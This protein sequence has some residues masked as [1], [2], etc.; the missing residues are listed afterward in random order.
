MIVK[1][2]NE[3]CGSWAFLAILLSAIVFSSCDA[4]DQPTKKE[5]TR[6]KLEST[7]PAKR[8]DGLKEAEQ[9]YGK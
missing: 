1:R 3:R 9:K 8:S 5:T 2:T 6:D 7:D 4:E